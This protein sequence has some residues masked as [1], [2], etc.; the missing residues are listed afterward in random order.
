MDLDASERDRAFL[1]I[2]A[3]RYYCTLFAALSL[4]NNDNIVCRNG[5][6][7][8][9]TLILPR[10]ELLRAPFRMKFNLRRHFVTDNFDYL[11]Y[12]PCLTPDGTLIVRLH[13]YLS[14]DRTMRLVHKAKTEP[15]FR[16]WRKDAIPH[17]GIAS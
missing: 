10:K 6:V 14:L 1:S 9:F 17:P 11:Q 2:G 16:L 7:E 3:H 4:C 15:M 12:V 13:E 8:E 5:R